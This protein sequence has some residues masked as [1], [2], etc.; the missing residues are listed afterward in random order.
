MSENEE[1]TPEQIR[2]ETE[3][4]MKTH[5]KPTQVNVSPE[6]K[7]AILNYLKKTSETK[8]KQG[9][10]I[11]EPMVNDEKVLEEYQQQV[12][13]QIEEEYA[14]KN[15]GKGTIPLSREMRKMEQ[16][17]QANDDNIIEATDRLDFLLQ[18]KDKRPEAYE[19]LKNKAFKGLSNCKQS[20]ETSDT[21]EG[22]KSI[23]RRILD[24]ENEAYRRKMGYKGE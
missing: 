19:I 2:Q 3:E 24:A 22:N 16:N 6:Q 14:K 17:N 7:Q 10:Q 21:F 15:G 18:L 9:E 13:K 5:Y 8:G 20:F 23:I 1:K 11:E 4:F 12:R